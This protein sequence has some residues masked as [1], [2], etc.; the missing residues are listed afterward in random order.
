MED[1]FDLIGDERYKPLKSTDWKWTMAN[2]Y[3]PKNGLKVFSCFACGGGSTMGYKLAGCEVLG[4]VEIDK[5]MNEVY[6]KNHKPKYNYLM[7]IRDFNKLDDLPEELY[8][9]DILDGSPPCFA[10]GTLVKTKNGYKPIEEIIVNDKVFTH[11]GNY[12]Q[13]YDIMSKQVNEY[14]ELKI[15]GCFPIKVTKN[16]PF[17]VR[18]MKRVGNSQKRVFSRPKWIEVQDLYIAKNNSGTIKEQNYIGFPINTI[19]ELPKW[20]GVEYTHN[21]YGKTKIIKHKY[22]LNFSNI[23]FWFFVGRYIGDGWLRDDR[24]EVLICCSK[25]EQLELKNIIEKANLKFTLSEERTTYR[26][27]IHNVELYEYL[28][29]FGK[30]AK[31]KELTNDIY[32]LPIKHLQSF[33]DGYISA[34]GYIENNKIYKISTVSEKLAFGIQQCIAKA[35]KQ[36]TTITIRK[37][38]NEILSRQI[39]TSI[40]YTISFRKTKCKQQHFIF[41]NNYLWLP[42]RNKTLKSEPLRVYNLSV[43]QDESYTVYNFSVHNCTTFSMAGER[44]DSWGKKKKFREGLKEQTL[45]DLSFVFIDTVAKLKPKCVI[46][47]NVEGLLLGNAWGYVQRIYKQ[48]DEIGYRVKHWLLKGEN[49]GVPQTRHR[50]FFIAL[51]NDIDFDLEKLD[52]SFNYEKIPYGVIKDGGTRKFG[53]RFYEIAKQA[54][55][56]DRSIADTRIRLG[57]KGSAFQTYYLRDNEVMM[58]VRSK[59]DIIDL[60]DIGYVSWQSIRNS[61]TFP[62]DYDFSP[63]KVSKVGYIC[64]M[65]VPPIMIKRIVTRIIEQGVLK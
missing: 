41:D 37:P 31:N 57:E 14:Y 47:E 45:D 48:F 20:N 17:Y 38:K 27:T 44:E 58:T 32:N 60:K 18:T 25:N 54:N 21:I 53:G 22:N 33:I 52:M 9:L 40:C 55:E 49:M 6:V 29:Q 34:D 8:N 63:N 35:Y 30:G 51:R 3:P 56:L 50:V 15:Q 61:Q 10:A 26:F 59:P 28:K 23:D 64:G 24:K 11:K 46:M 39:N 36:P 42:F 4:C 62:Q 7:D 19:E 2:D 5:A 65:S 12:K 13:V 16:H 1:L 43:E